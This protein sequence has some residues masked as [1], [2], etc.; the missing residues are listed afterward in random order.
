MKSSSI[1]LREVSEEKKIEMNA[2]D[3]PL[4]YVEIDNDD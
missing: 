4:R 3:D 1:K 2:D